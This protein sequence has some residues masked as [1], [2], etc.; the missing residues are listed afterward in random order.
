MNFEFPGSI[1]LADFV[2]YP[3]E[4]YRTHE[5]QNLIKEGA[6]AVSVFGMRPNDTESAMG[7]KLQ[8][9][10]RRSLFPTTARRCKVVFQSL[11]CYI[12][13]SG[14][15]DILLYIRSLNITPTINIS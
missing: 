12:V 13:F 2:F 1:L 7:C 9:A 4:V 11:D 14:E 5:A 8:T 6:S 10:D 3:A 15:S